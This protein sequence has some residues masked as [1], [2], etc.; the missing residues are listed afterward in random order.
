VTILAG[1][2]LCR[3]EGRTYLLR[4]LDCLHIP[5][6]TAHVVQNASSHELLIAHW[7]FATP[8]PSRELVENTFTTE[9]R[10]FSNPNHDDPEHIV[11]FE[12]AR[13]YDLADGT[14]FCDLFAGRFGADG[15]CGGYGEFNPG[16]S[17]PCHIHE[18]D[19]S[20]SI[21]T[22]E[23]ICEVM[24]QRYRLS[25]YD[26]AFVPRGRPH[27]FLNESQGCMAMVWVYAAGEPERVIVEARRCTE[28]P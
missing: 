9:D 19:E 12:D 14:Q 10:R 21:V 1:E 18:Y 22:G 26:T 25:N 15:I 13:K 8:I 2:A 27:R 5:A 3:V 11:R 17:L 6:G 20:I 4:P 24:G 28:R 23:A 7:S 16:S